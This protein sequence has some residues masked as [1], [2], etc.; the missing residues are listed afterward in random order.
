M[1]AFT[2]AG[3]TFNRALA[4][5]TEVQVRPAVLDDSPALQEFLRQLGYETTMQ[6]L[7]RRLLLLA[8]NGTDPVL[9]A[10]HGTRV[11]GVIAIHWTSMLFADAP[12][13][14]ITTLVVDSAARGLGVG[15]LLVEAGAKRARAAGCD[16]LELTTAL[17]RTNAQAFYKAIGFVASS[18]RLHRPLSN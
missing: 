1:V 8:K 14:R 16:T 17:N 18:L 7:G 12:V 9:V 6:M 4:S 15:R 2:P 10:V 11:L 3:Q 5:G 13:A